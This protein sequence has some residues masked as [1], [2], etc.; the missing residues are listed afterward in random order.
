M[1]YETLLY[2]VAG[3]VAAVTLNRPDRMNSLNAVMRAELLDALTR[4]P[5]EAR[6]VVLTG[7]SS[8]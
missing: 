3:D 1:S 5:R 4:A 2:A 8:S 6:A 7:A